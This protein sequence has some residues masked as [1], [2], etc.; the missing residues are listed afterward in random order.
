[1]FF[2]GGVQLFFMGMIGE[3][4]RDLRAGAREKP[5]VF[6]REACQFRRP[7]A[8]RQRDVRASYQ[9]FGQRLLD[10]RDDRLN[11]EAGGIEQRLARTR[12]GRLAALL[13]NADAHDRRPDRVA[14]K[15]ARHRR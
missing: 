12:A 1:M 8:A 5:V 2:F 3:Y 13:G 9:G 7:A 11:R 10:P 4:A 14:G 15:R 6:E